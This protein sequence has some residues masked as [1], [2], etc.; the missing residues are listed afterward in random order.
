MMSIWPF[1]DLDV[2][3]CDAMGVE[4]DWLWCITSV[5]ICVI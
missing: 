1:K 2:V 4:L 5:L 3:R